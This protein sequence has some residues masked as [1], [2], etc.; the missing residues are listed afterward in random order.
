LVV[1]VEGDVIVSTVI[2]LGTAQ[3]LKQL[4]TVVRTQALDSVQG[5]LQTLGRLR[6]LP[7][8]RTPYYI[9]FACEQMEK[10]LE[11]NENAMGLFKELGV[12]QRGV[13]IQGLL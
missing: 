4:T 2:K 11:Y 5:I 1:L 9:Y 13:V 8:G 12:E 10:H 6:K 7:D 3:D